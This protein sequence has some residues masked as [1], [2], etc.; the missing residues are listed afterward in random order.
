M[1][2]LRTLGAVAVVALGATNVQ[3]GGEL[4]FDVNALTAT[5]SGTFGTGFTGTMT[6]TD[7]FGVATSPNNSVLSDILINGVAQNIAAGQLTSFSA[8]IS[9]VAGLV[10][11]GSLTI[12][13]NTVETYTATIT[14]DAFS[15]IDEGPA[16]T[17]SVDG[18]TITGLFSGLTGGL[19]AGV[20]VSD[21]DVLGGVSGFFR[22][23]FFT[24]DASNTDT[25][26]DIDI[27]AVIPLPTPAALTGVGLLGLAGLRRRR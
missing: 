5:A 12:V 10:T 3:A 25:D 4:Q 23:F 16:G 8:T 11:T 15:D 19:F 20:D 27:V 2:L 6:L 26:T 22:E 21:W 1:K 18:L 13:A 14:G 24:P 9:F 17:F 7:D